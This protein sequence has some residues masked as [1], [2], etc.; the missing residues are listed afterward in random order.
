MMLF[1][2]S[3]FLIGKLAFF[4]KQLYGFIISLR[5]IPYLS[6]VHYFDCHST[7]LNLSICVLSINIGKYYLFLSSGWIVVST[8]IHLHT[9]G[10]DFGILSFERPVMT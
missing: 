4:N 9:T 2:H 10:F 7:I 1:I 5:R 3:L 8:T 6:K